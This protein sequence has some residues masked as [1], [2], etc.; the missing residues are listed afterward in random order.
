MRDHKVQFTPNLLSRL[1]KLLYLTFKLFDVYKL[2]S[3]YF[4]ITLHSSSKYEEDKSVRRMSVLFTDLLDLLVGFCCHYLRTHAKLG[5]GKQVQQGVELYRSLFQDHGE[6]YFTLRERLRILND[7]NSIF[8]QIP[9]IIN[10]DY[11]WGM[12]R[13]GLFDPDN[14]CRKISMAVLKNNLKTLGQDTIYKGILTQQ[15]FETHWTTFFDLYDTL[16]SFGSH[17]TKVSNF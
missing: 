3:K 16:E 13:E 2:N 1:E 15:E 7:L 9:E 11:Y 8:N 10:A 12:I 17:L 14:Y 4:I 5:T 6:E